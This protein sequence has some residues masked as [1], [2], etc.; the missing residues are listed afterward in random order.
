MG[1]EQWADTGAHG[2]QARMGNDGL[3]CTR[4]LGGERAI[5]LDSLNSLAKGP[6][7]ASA[8]WAHGHP[9]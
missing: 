8:V 6:T 1:A 5:E 7:E 4:P 9:T 3:V 2:L